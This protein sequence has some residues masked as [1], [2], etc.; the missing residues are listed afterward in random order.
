M[1]TTKNFLCASLALAALLFASTDITAAQRRGAQ[2]K[3]TME[4]RRAQEL[5][6][7]QAEEERYLIRK[8]L[9]PQQM[10]QQNVPAMQQQEEPQEQSCCVCMEDTDLRPI[11]CVN[12]AKHSER[13]CGSCLND[14]KNQ[15]QARGELALC[16]ICRGQLI[17]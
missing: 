5:A 10:E 3:L 7:R 6:K 1:K 11:P 17:G 15:A 4:Q 8:G 12:G 14:I 13:I 16:P 9:A 2:P